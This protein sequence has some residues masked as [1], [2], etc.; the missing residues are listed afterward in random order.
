M[1]ET[2]APCLAERTTN[3][4]N[5]ERSDYAKL[6]QAYMELAAEYAVLRDLVNR[7]Q[8]REEVIKASS[9]HNAA[10]MQTYLREE[11]DKD[12]HI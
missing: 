3:R 4:A 6:Y 11:A 12:R 9:A 10:E 5:P 2:I 8:K 7:W 1:T